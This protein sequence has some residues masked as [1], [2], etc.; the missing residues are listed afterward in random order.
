MSAPPNRNQGEADLDDVESPP[1]LAF[2]RHAG[3]GRSLVARQD[4]AA[5]RELPYGGRIV[6][7]NAGDH[8]LVVQ[9][10]T[11]A[12]QTAVADDFQSRLDEPG[13]R[14]SNRL[15][16]QREKEL[17][18][19]A[20]VASHIAWFD[21][22]RM[23]VV[24]LEDFAA[25]PEYRE[26]A[27][28]RDLLAVAEQ[29]ATAEG[30]VLG[31]VN[32]DRHAW[33]ERQGWSPLRGQGHTRA[34]ARTVLAYLD[35]QERARKRRKGSLEVRTWRHFELD[36]VRSI[37]ETTAAELWGPLFRS[38][39]CWQWLIGRKAQDQVL[40]AVESNG[41]AS[42]NGDSGLMLLGDAAGYAVV[43]GSCIVEMMSL[44]K[45]PAARVHMLARACRDAIDRDHHSISLYT[46]ASDP[47]H[48]L[49]VTAGGAWI[50]DR[51][52]NGP[53]LLMRL[54]SPE[55]WVERCY[56][57]W[58]QRAHDAGVPRPTE[59][60]I[61]TTDASYRFTLTR[62]SARLEPMGDRPADWVECD[63]P[64]F[65]SLL[66][67]NLA[68][69]EAVEQKALRLSTPELKATLTALFAPRLFW[70]SPL[71]FMRL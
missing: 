47:L 15:L 6:T 21:G 57:L 51:K 67:G 20:H 44:P 52:E 11:Q 9:L 23:P 28:D 32:A 31:L 41:A 62:R 26:S 63:R 30:A 42:I 22:Q 45:F 25:L 5:V 8:P 35:A 54:L 2:T 29:I 66:A 68:I 13:Y 55:R 69:N 46:P 33:F 16:V 37:Y 61:T 48:E 60:G 70:Q 64:T 1:A 19:H 17:L 49:M 59:I 50:S 34:N 71:E 53:R 10:L 4:R 39:E 43:R 58:R 24:K 7:G 3:N 12:R 38:E 65:E 40:L 36:A 14:P 56:T 27:Y 18:A